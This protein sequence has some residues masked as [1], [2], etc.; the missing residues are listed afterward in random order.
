MRKLSIALMVSLCFLGISSAASAT[1]VQMVWTGANGAADLLGNTVTLPQG[2][3]SATLTLDV[4]INIDSRGLAGAFL[5][6][7]FDTDLGNEVNLLGFEEIN[8]SKINKNQVVKKTLLP[9]RAGVQSTLESTGSNG[10]FAFEFDGQTLGIGPASSTLTFAR[11]V[12]STNNQ[13]VSNDGEDIFSSGVVGCNAP[14][15]NISN[16]PG[17]F[18]GAIVNVIPEPGTIVLLGLGVGALGLA[19]RRRGRK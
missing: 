1:S 11:L 6:F 9:L 4:V 12:F 19:G 8:W 18:N 13:N 3:G 16:E 7:D 5:T 15:C 14:G 10:G 17:L 2:T